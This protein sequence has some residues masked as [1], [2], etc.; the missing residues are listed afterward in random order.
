MAAQ[1]SSG[2]TSDGPTADVR[3]SGTAP[4]LAMAVAVVAVPAIIVAVLVALVV[5]GLPFWVGIP[6]G[7]LVAAAFVWSRVR[8]AADIVLTAMEAKPTDEATHPRLVNLVEGLSLAGGVAEPELYVIDDK[9]RNAAAIAQG[10]R[11]AIVATTGLL[12][13][14]DRVALEGVVAELLVRAR[15]GDAEA[16]SI[17]AAV[18]GW[19][20]AGPIAPLARP[21][22]THGLRRL[23][24]E[25]RDLEADRDAVALTRYPPGLLAALSAIRAGSPRPAAISPGT[26]HVWLVPPASVE[27]VDGP[28]HTAPL[29][30]R[31]DVLAEL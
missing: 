7:L 17:G 19:M 15:S 29:D 14:V 2:D 5:P 18:F 25:D 1:S 4:V 27:E 10:D 20:M 22:A 12:D 6:V 9:A 3:R 11:T 26:E 13:A 8:R 21:A 23:L 28:V 16:A 31:I 24:A 30:L